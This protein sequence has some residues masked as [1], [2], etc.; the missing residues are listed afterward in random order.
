MKAPAS[1]VLSMTWACFPPDGGLRALTVFGLSAGLKKNGDWPFI[2]SLGL[3]DLAFENSDAS[4]IG[5]GIALNAEVSGKFDPNRLS[6]TANTSLT[7]DKGE[8]LYDRFYL[9]LKKK[10]FFFLV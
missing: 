9:D 10:R 1:S 3:R 5:E 7:V 8:I 6:L 2:F 4:A